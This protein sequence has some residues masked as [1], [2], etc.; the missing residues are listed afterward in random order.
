MTALKLDANFLI[1][2]FYTVIIDSS[3]AFFM[4]TAKKISG[5]GLLIV[6][7]HWIGTIGYAERKIV[8]FLVS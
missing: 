2:F 3:E 6:S 8:F 4:D 1:F 5:F 7:S